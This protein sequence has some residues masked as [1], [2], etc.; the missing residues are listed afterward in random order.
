MR[1]YQHHDLF[2]YGKVVCAFI[3]GSSCDLSS[4]KF[5]NVF[6]HYSLFGRTHSSGKFF[7][8]PIEVK[9]LLL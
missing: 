6:S 9:H 8:S 5:T 7:E 2:L 3:N 1:I 4:Y